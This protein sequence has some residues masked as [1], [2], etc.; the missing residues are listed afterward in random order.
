M[1]K[2]FTH[3]GEE[4]TAINLGPDVP[5]MATGGAKPPLVPEI[6]IILFEAPDETTRTIPLVTGKFA[7]LSE[8]ELRDLYENAQPDNGE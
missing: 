2:K 5:V 7:H 1:S 8:E 4:I 6:D 3:N